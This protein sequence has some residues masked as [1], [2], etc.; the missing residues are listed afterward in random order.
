M[1]R[2]MTL[3][4]VAMPLAGAC[5]QERIVGSGIA[6]TET[7]QMGAFDQIDLRIAADL[8]ITIGKP[9]PLTIETDDNILPW[10]ETE[11]RDGKLIISSDKSF[12]TENEPDISVTVADLKGL[13]VSGSGDVIV[14]GLDNKAL[15]VQ[16]AGSADVRLYGKTTEL[17][18]KISGSA[19]VFA[20]NLQAEE[21]EVSITGSGDVRVHVT[22]KLEVRIT[23]SGDVV[24]R[25]SPRVTAKV[26]G[27]GNVT[28]D[29][30][31][32]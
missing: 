27:S 16:L 28:K 9:S 15:K 8:K 30:K 11:V 18:I 12:K 10:I 4:L 3:V 23:G 29:K 22:Q 1:K 13:S 19:D 17:D 2:I 7:R 5:A 6:T 25:G 21:A 32:A 14:T 24:Y 20:S 26:T 31:S